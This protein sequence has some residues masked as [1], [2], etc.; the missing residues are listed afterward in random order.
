MAGTQELVDFVD[1]IDD[2]LTEIATVATADGDDEEVL[3]SLLLRANLALRYILVVEDVLPAGEVLS[4]AV[5]LVVRCLQEAVDEKKL[6]HIRGRPSICIP[7]EQLAMLLG[8]HFKVTD[9]AR[10]LMVSPRTIRRR[11]IQY[12]LEETASYSDM[13]DGD[14]DSLVSDFVHHNPNSGLRSLEGLLRSQGIRI[15]RQRVRES[16]MRVDPRGME[17]RFGML[18]QRKKYSVPLPNSLW[19]LDGHHK[20]IRWRIVT[21][22]C[23]D[24]FSRLPLYLHASTN[25][26]AQTVLD[27]FLKAVQQYGLPSRVRCDKGGENVDVS[28]F[29]LC[30][31]SRGPGR[32]SCI[33]GRNIHN[34]H[35]ERLWRNV[36]GGCIHLFLQFVLHNGRYWISGS[37]EYF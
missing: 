11:I 5:C 21:H 19:H 31:P 29:M 15:Q 26:R 2:I 8:F 23:I 35:I 37:Y 3:E 22:G 27:C 28:H 20:L 34:Q 30:H 33:T 4:N 25:N 13:S 16:L 24:G 12:G 32:R 17:A 36:F 9:I 14:L 10:V 7:E 18:V 1:E 6:S